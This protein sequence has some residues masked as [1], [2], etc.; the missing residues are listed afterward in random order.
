MVHTNGNVAK[1][2]TFLYVQH[3]ANNTTIMVQLLACP[4][5]CTCTCEHVC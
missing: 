3:P 5:T 1:G 4:R 2:E